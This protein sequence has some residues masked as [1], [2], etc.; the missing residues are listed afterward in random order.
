MKKLFFWALVLFCPF[1][2]AQTVFGLK[3]GYSL[4]NLAAK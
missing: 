2:D 1:M 4:S 3:A